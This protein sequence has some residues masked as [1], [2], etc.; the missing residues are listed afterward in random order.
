[1]PMRPS[2]L[3][4][5]FAVASSMVS[6]QDHEGHHAPPPYA[7]DTARSIKALTPAEVADLL[8]GR[9]MG[10]ARAAELNGYPGPL[11]VLELADDLGLS[12]AQRA[13]IEQ[14]RT[15]IQ[16]EARALGAQVVEIEGHLDALFAEDRAT[17]DA[18]GRM[19]A[20]L[21][22]VQG[23]LRAGH[24]RAH[25]ATHAALTPDQ[26]AHYGRLRGYTTD[27]TAY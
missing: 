15:A 12:Q 27:A 7:A 26:V 21:A 19:T 1:M 4:L 2:F 16:A 11:H 9:G 17:T 8:E 24:L 25:I 18:L 3:C 13:A 23:R 6:A 5:L 20:H 14:I 10:L 22:E